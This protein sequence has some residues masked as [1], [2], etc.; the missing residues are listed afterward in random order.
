MPSHEGSRKR[1]KMS[2]T[3]GKATSPKAA[4]TAST[5]TSAVQMA[6]AQ[7]P[8]TSGACHHE[9]ALKALHTDTDA[10][11]QLVTCKICDRLLYEPYALSCGHTY[12]YSCLSQWLVSNRKKT[13]PDCR[14]VITQ[15]PTPSYIIK[16]LVLVFVSRSELLPDGE[17]AEEHNKL[18]KDEA[19]I[20]ADDR[21]NADPN[22]G[23]LFKGCFVRGRRRTML[24]LH[25][26]GDG[27]DRCP[28][29]H[30]ELE[31]GF[32]NHCGMRVDG[33]HTGFSDISDD[34]SDIT[35]DEELDEEL[36]NMADHDDAVY[37]ADGQDDLF[38]GYTTDDSITLTR[39][40]ERIMPAYRQPRQTRR[41]GSA[42]TPIDLASSDEES[43]E[44]DEHDPTMDDFIDDDLQVQDGSVEDVDQ[45]ETASHRRLGHRSD[46]TVQVA[47]DEDIDQEDIDEAVRSARRH[48]LGH[49]RAPVLTISDDEDDEVDEVDAAATSGA[50]AETEQDSDDEGPVRA[51]S[52]RNKRSRVAMRQRPVRRISSD[53]ESSEDDEEADGE[54]GEDAGNGGFSPLDES[55]REETVSVRSDYDS[56]APSSIYP[57]FEDDEEDNESEESDDDDGWG[58]LSPFCVAYEAILTIRTGT[59][60]ETPRD[61]RQPPNS[62]RHRLQP[63]GQRNH[64]HRTA[65]SGHPIQTFVPPAPRYG[66]EATYGRGFFHGSHQTG[67]PAIPPA[68]DRSGSARTHLQARPTYG[69]PPML[70]IRRPQ[71]MG[72]HTGRHPFQL[73]DTLSRIN[74][75]HHN[76]QTRSNANHHSRSAASSSQGS[77]GGGVDVQSASS[78][79]SSRTIGPATTTR[80][81]K[82]L[83]VSSDESVEDARE[84]YEY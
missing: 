31:D 60:L 67:R 66:R 12:C 11:R 7:Q 4:P 39:R 32:C 75:D 56:E 63:L 36:A 70:G 82:G 29:C 14:A 80:P 20:V 25:D 62:S 76:Q 48:R 83:S 42:Q 21:A 30:W 79:S 57:T 43:S 49:R 34:D 27:V 51:G 16:E 2:P 15:Q 59:E 33:S 35:D 26:P 81:K 64:R 72:E 77:T 47:S 19:K 55:A 23:G 58:S 44:D 5:S 50:H 40:T 18:A 65:L 8:S 9:S 54:G 45:H 22:T 37:G 6:A 61:V 53:R 71:P 78:S 38:G 68:S 46:L 73:S 24:P 28:D 10:M 3:E 74:Q 17:T 1:L 41:S 84:L 69:P 52:Q 13:C